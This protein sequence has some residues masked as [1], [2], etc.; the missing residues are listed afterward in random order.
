MEHRSENEGGERAPRAISIKVT[1]FMQYTC[2]AHLHG[3]SRCYM[4]NKSLQK[5][6]DEN[7]V[8][9]KEKYTG[10][11]QTSAKVQQEPRSLQLKSINKMFSGDIVANT[12]RS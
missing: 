4:L 10:R 1:G 5:L 8:Q 9:N 11:K 3:H 6:L 2:T 12:G 7:Q